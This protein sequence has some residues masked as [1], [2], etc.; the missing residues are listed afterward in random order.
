MAV[1]ECPSC[2]EIL[3][4]EPP[5]KRHSAFSSAKPKQKMPHSKI[6]QKR[7]RCKNKDCKKTVT[8]YWYAPLE[9]LCF[10]GMM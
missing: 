1:F 9:C 5:D 2:N 8:V 4:V 3:E 6:I 10:N 7:V